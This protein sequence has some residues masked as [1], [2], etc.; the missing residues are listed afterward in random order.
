MPNYLISQ[1][2]NIKIEQLQNMDM[3]MGMGK[4]YAGLNLHTYLVGWIQ[5]LPTSISIYLRPSTCFLTAFLS[6]LLAV[7]LWERPS[8]F[9]KRLS[10]I[11]KMV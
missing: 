9:T 4:P 5:L 7:R 10:R 2:G 3:D 11:L 6:I 8:I 1:Q